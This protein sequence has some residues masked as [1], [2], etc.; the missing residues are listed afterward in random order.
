M[1]RPNLCTHGCSAVAQR[2]PPAARAVGV[3]PGRPSCGMQ[4]LDAF[5]HYIRDAPG[6]PH[7]LA[8]PG[9]RSKIMPGNAAVVLQ[10]LQ[11]KPEWCIL[12]ICAG[13]PARPG[14]GGERERARNGHGGACAPDRRGRQPAQVPAGRQPLPAGLLASLYVCSTGYEDVQYLALALLLPTAFGEDDT[15][16]AN[17]SGSGTACSGRFGSPLTGQEHTRCCAPGR[18]VL[19]HTL[20]HVQV[21]VPDPR[22]AMRRGQDAMFL[23]CHNRAGAAIHPGGYLFGHLGLLQPSFPACTCTAGLDPACPTLRNAHH[24]SE[25]IER[26][27]TLHHVTYSN[28][29]RGPTRGALRAFSDTF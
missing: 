1:R 18:D 3:V 16:Q 7:Q 19:L 25:G 15:L 11:A 17:C 5:A 12:L 20:L 4:P 29:T 23:T 8:A 22:N 2:A 6:R 10:T 24:T 27:S 9:V 13:G 14:P 28:I 21:A 26:R